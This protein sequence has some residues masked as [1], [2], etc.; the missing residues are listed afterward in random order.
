M[1]IPVFISC[2]SKLNKRQDLSKVFILE[3]LS[4]YEL[5]P[6]SLGKDEY[7]TKYPLREIYILAKHCSGGLILGYAQNTFSA[8]EQDTPVVL[9]TPWNN[10]EAG[11]FFSLGLPILVFRENGVEGGV[12]DPGVTDVFI[13]DLPVNSMTE[14]DKTVIKDVIR[15]WQSE[16]LKS[17]Y[18]L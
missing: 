4:R 10:I 6:C 11:I 13:N 14:H 16:V 3:E 9:P 7:P 5:E 1:K 18:E 12:F 15:K 2:P 8:N 17:F